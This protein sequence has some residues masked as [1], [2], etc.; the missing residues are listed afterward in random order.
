MERPGFW[1]EESTWPPRSVEMRRY[2][3]APGRFG[4]DV[5][6]DAKVAIRSPLT[7]GASSGEWMPW[8]P[9]GSGAHLA[10]DQREA[11]GLSLCF[12]T[13]AV[14]TDTE[15][16]GQPLI[17][18]AVSS[19]QTCGQI[20]ARLCDVAPDGTSTRITYG[21]LNLS[22][23][24]GDEQPVPVEPDQSYQVKIPL[25]PIGWYL[26]AGHRFRIAVSTSYFPIVWPMPRHATLTLDLAGCRLMLPLR[27]D[28]KRCAA[29]APATPVNR[30]GLAATT[31]RAPRLER[32]RSFNVGSSVLEIVVDEDNGEVRLDKDGLTFGSTMKRTYS[33]AAND[34]LSARCATSATW[35]LG[36]GDWTTRVA[37][38]ADVT[39][40]GESFFVNTRIS[41]HEGEHEVFARQDIRKI[42]R[43]SA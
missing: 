23:R 24:D 11:D 34:P 22:H 6:S 28:G 37:V 27:N 42:P 29:P 14:A 5:H 32:R 12:D 2:G 8:Y 20:V 30:P 35:T 43:G 9:A 21:F 36:R 33:V 41:A 38:D 1:V 13:V 7:V 40:D 19:D 25:A 26:K 4:V 3:L 10:E 39:S 18:L 16:L 15:L 17:S 31:L